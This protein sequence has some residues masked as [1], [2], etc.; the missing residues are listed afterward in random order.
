[1]SPWEDPPTNRINPQN[2]RT[3]SPLIADTFFNRRHHVPLKVDEKK[4]F[5]LSSFTLNFF[6]PF[7]LFFSPPSSLVSVSNNCSAIRSL[8]A[9]HN[10][11]NYCMFHPLPLLPLTRE[12]EQEAWRVTENPKK[13]VKNRASSSPVSVVTPRHATR[14]LMM[15]MKMVWAARQRRITFLHTF[16]HPPPSTYSLPLW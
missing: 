5:L 10:P 13:Y 4:F 9:N 3:K 16:S 7:S 1:M 2:P 8:I 11:W 6:I 12:E 14:L 15:M